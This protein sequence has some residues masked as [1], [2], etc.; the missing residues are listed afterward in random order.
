MLIPGVDVGHAPG[1]AKNSYGMLESGEFQRAVGHGERGSG[2]LLERLFIAGRQEGGGSAWITTGEMDCRKRQAYKSE[3]THGHFP[4]VPR[5][6]R[7]RSLLSV[8]PRF[9]L[10]P[11]PAKRAE[12]CVRW[13]SRGPRIQS[14]GWE[15]G[16]GIQSESLFPILSNHWLHCNYQINFN[17]N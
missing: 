9:L 4:R 8:M 11:G 17:P 13:A 1:I 7:L 10:M 12:A 3:E 15:K 5:L 16:T 2:S 6:H 14:L